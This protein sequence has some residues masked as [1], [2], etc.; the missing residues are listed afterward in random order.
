MITLNINSSIR[1][2]TFR[3]SLQNRMIKIVPQKRDSGDLCRTLFEYYTCQ[4]FRK[5]VREIEF[6]A[7]LYTCIHTGTCVEEVCCAVICQSSRQLNV[8]VYTAISSVVA[9]SVNSSTHYLL[10]ILDFE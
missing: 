10:Q 6:H 2:N 5:L 4:K 9:N 1:K 3:L 7:F 8:L